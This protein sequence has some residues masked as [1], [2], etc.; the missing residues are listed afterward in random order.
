MTVL[1]RRG[2]ARVAEPAVEPV[3]LSEA[4]LYLRVD[5]DAEDDLIEDLITAARE[6]AEEYL[7]RSLITQSWKLSYNDCAPEEVFLPRGPVASVTSVTAFDRLGAATVISPD[8]YYLDATQDTLIFDTGIL[9]HRVEIVYGT[10]Y[11]DAADVPRPIKAGLL[12]HVAE[13]YDRRGDAEVAM[14]L[15]VQRLY[16][17]YRDARV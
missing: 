10:G 4:M 2:L 14:P 15:Q 1:L 17:P 8:V 12:A 13:L 3:T 7:R 5:G 9:S 11:G 16:A 6:Q